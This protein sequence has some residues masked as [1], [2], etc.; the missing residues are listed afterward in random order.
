MHT[1]AS[2]NELAC[3]VNTSSVDLRTKET[4]ADNYR[5]YIYVLV[6]MYIKATHKISTQNIERHRNMCVAKSESRLP[7]LHTFIE[8][9]I[10]K[11]D[12]GDIVLIS[13]NR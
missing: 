7:N 6:L 2:I 8:G 1:L 12:F 13:K 10:K 9:I 3:Y 4:I 5:P 11:L